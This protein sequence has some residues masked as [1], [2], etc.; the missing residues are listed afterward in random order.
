MTWLV[1]VGCLSSVSDKELGL[2]FKPTFCS[3]SDMGFSDSAHGAITER[4]PYPDTVPYD[5]WCSD[6]SMVVRSD[7]TV[8]TVGRAEICE[9]H[10]YDNRYRGNIDFTGIKVTLSLQSNAYDA[11]AKYIGKEKTPKLGDFKSWQGG[12]VFRIPSPAFTFPM[13]RGSSNPWHREGVVGD[14]KP[15]KRFNF[16]F[17]EIQLRRNLDEQGRT[18]A[19]KGDSHADRTDLKPTLCIGELSD[20]PSQNS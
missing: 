19:Y 14:L 13:P 6:R 15:I 11:Y 3:V 16:D 20:P 12:V 7:S 9:G 1:L 17:I 5:Y 8:R 4:P 18:V 2:A 10:V